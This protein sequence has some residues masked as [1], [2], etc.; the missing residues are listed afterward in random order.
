MIIGSMAQDQDQVEQ[1]TDAGIPAVTTNANNI[2][3]TYENITFLGEVTGHQEEAR[4]L[5]EEMKSGFEEIKKEA[6]D[7]G[8]TI[9]FEVSPL[10]YGLW[11][12]GN[13]TFMQELCD[14]V[15]VENIFSD[16]DGWA[17]ISEEDVLQRNP[18][19]IA[20]VTMYT[21]Q[22][23]TPDE[24]ILGRANWQD[25]TAVK[26]NH[27]YC[28]DNNMM[29]RPGPRLVEAARLLADFVNE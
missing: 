20:T 18:D 6:A 7:G 21:G 2:A 8:K 12:A 26:E 25:V 22:G 14:I 24:E 1:L 19:Y 28:A 13:N 27:I 5:V 17:E 11:T 29:T 10:E 15:K 4:Q 23:P 3:E 9:Y 16:V